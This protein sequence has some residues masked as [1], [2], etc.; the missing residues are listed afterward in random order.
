MLNCI[1]CV[2]LR[3]KSWTTIV[4]RQPPC[5]QQCLSMFGWS[6]FSFIQFYD[7]KMRYCA[8]LQA[9]STV[10]N[11]PKCYIDSEGITKFIY[12][13]GVLVRR[14][15]TYLFHKLVLLSG[16]Y[17]CCKWVPYLCENHVDGGRW[18]T[19]IFASNY[20]ECET[21][22]V[23]FD[24]KHAH[25]TVKHYKFLNFSAPYCRESKTQHPTC[26][27]VGIP[28]YAPAFCSDTLRFQTFQFFE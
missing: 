17:L 3:K 19:N 20:L 9:L 15:K 6:S 5:L 12:I 2:M 22:S 7:L 21:K 25:F 14:Y 10:Y 26:R 1:T 24:E 4:C 8:T 11:T 28:K 13:C 16:A 27:V 18:K 23:C